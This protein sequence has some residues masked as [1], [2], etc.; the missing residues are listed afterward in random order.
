VQAYF[1]SAGESLLREFSAQ[2][3]AASANLAFE[4]AAAIHVRVEKLKPFSAS[5]PRSSA[6]STA[7]RVDHSA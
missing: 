1:D 3:D 4:D 2:R 7:F 6:V 5:F